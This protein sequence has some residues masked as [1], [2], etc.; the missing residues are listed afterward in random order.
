MGKAAG[1]ADK[2]P[3]PNAVRRAI[4]A[5]PV[6]PDNMS[7]D[8]S[9]ATLPEAPVFRPTA[10]EFADPM[11]YIKSIRPI[12]EPAGICKIIPPSGWNPKCWIDRSTFKCRT[13]VQRLNELDGGTRSNF[14]FL[15]NVSEFL[16]KTTVRI[17]IGLERRV[18]CLA[19][20]PLERCQQVSMLAGTVA[21]ADSIRRTEAT[22]FG[23]AIQT[24]LRERR[25]R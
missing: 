15:S 9:P 7:S 24:S 5:Q 23:D 14:F 1:A 8:L 22:R 6:L 2:K 13:R 25:L 12:A 16:E 19:G 11:Q 3:P 4:Q 21:Q 20:A 17:R 18:P 10:A